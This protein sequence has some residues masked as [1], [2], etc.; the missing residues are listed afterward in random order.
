[1]ARGDGSDPLSQAQNSATS[2]S[3]VLDDGRFMS[4]TSTLAP[5]LGGKRHGVD[6]GQATVAAGLRR[7]LEWQ[8]QA[9]PGARST[10]PTAAPAA[11]KIARRA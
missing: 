4:A 5:S 6:A 9:M 3:I 11:C 1:M 10:G 2:S 7:S 8:T